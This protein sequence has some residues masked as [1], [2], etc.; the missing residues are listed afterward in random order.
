[1]KNQNRSAA[2]GR[3]AMKSLGGGGGRGG[4]QLVCG[5]PTL[6]LK[7]FLFI[8]LSAILFIGAK[9]FYLVGIKLGNIAEKSES[10]WPKGSVGDSI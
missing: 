7:T 1:M 8:A 3:P 9:R 4:L 6:A 2:L 10:H 5:R